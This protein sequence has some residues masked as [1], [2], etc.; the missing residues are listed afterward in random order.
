MHVSAISSTSGGDWIL[1]N[2]YCV[3]IRH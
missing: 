2:V 3:T 1:A